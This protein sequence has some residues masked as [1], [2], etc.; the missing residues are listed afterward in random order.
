VRNCL[1]KPGEFLF[2]LVLKE[3][4][5]SIFPAKGHQV[6]REEVF[7]MADPP[8]NLDTGNLHQLY[9]PA[10]ISARGS[11]VSDYFFKNNLVTVY[12]RLESCM[13]MP[14]SEGI[15]FGNRDLGNP[16]RLE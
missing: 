12:I 6:D 3:N 4:I 9:A 1:R 5:T 7:P 13:I 15:G 16:C 14:P 10:A 2:R 8:E 11:R